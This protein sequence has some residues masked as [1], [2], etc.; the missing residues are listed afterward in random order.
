MADGWGDLRQRVID[1][2]RPVRWA[3]A[4]LGF[5]SVMVAPL[6]MLTELLR[7]LTT[8]DFGSALAFLGIPLLTVGWVVLTPAGILLA[9][10]RF[11]S[12]ALIGA[13]L[14]LFNP[15]LVGIP[16]GIWALVQLNRPAVRAVFRDNG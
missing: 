4:L 13:C 2:L 5:A 3:M 16:I 6:W 15:L 7:S 10:G 11:R 1:G 12:F 14:A 9:L 8:P